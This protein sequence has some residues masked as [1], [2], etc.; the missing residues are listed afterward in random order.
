M[1]QLFDERMVAAYFNNVLISQN[2]H[3]IFKCKTG[4]IGIQATQPIFG[5]R[6]GHLI[7]CQPSSLL[8]SVQ[9]DLLGYVPTRLLNKT[10]KCAG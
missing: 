5:F 7:L 9:A 6:P 2:E 8:H 1:S 4:I 3:I 10:I